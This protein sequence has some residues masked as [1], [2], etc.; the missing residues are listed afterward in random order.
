M[1]LNTSYANKPKRHCNN[2]SANILNITV[3]LIYTIKFKDWF[4]IS[5]LQCSSFLIGELTVRIFIL[6]CDVYI[7]SSFLLPLLFYFSVNQCILLAIEN[8]H[9]LLCR[10]ILLSSVF[11]CRNKIIYLK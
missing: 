2:K 7:F 9:P 1:R 11:I 6:S 5:P 10:V 4:I 3:N 8:K